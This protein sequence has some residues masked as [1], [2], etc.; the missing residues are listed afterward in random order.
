MDETEQLPGSWRV[1]GYV[2]KK[3]EILVGMN[4]SGLVLGQSFN[5][6]NQVN[7]FQLQGSARAGFLI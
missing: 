1:A 4:Y 2:R 5:V 3:S 7:E 6:N